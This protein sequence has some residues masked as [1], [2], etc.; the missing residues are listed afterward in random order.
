MKTNVDQ[1]KVILALYGTDLDV[2]DFSS[3]AKLAWSL[4]QNY[5]YDRISE[6]AMDYAEN[7][8]LL[9]WPGHPHP[10]AR[11]NGAWK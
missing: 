6:P 9:N 8:G 3:A 1:F 7:T 4:R 5:K 10:Y 2:L 11:D